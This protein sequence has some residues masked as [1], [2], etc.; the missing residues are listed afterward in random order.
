MARAVRAGVVNRR[1][2]V[3]F[4]GT[5]GQL[6][7]ASLRALA[8]DHEIVGVVCAQRP[9]PP[10]TAR[11]WVG[12]IVRSLVRHPPDGLTAI[13]RARGAPL[14]Y[15]DSR[16][17]LSSVQNC[18]AQHDLVCVSSFPW[19]VPESLL[20]QAP[21][22][23]INLHT[24]L[25]PRHRGPLTLFWVYHANDRE[26]GVTV[27]RMTEAFDAGDILGQQAFELERGYPVDALN[28]RHVELGPGLLQRCAQS[29]ARGDASPSPQ[30]ERLATYAPLVRPGDRM[31]DFAAWDAERVWH[32]LA[33]L[34]PR[35]IEPLADAESNA[36][37]YTGVIGH[38]PGVTEGPLGTVRRLDE[39]RLALQCRDGVVY[40]RAS[41]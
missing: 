16:S 37:R 23:G 13:A 9:A 5:T 21:L 8:E 22:G 2:R 3:L 26:T 29:L 17:E 38:E 1:L 20:A 25:L 41:R 19:K 36:I 15:V 32:F 11:A 10:P 4:F 6:S 28:R 33:G 35:F 31:V 7:T 12:R 14:W 34:F 39:T 24:S 30:D 27:H 40:L 18:A